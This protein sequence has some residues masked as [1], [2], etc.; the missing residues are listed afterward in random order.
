MMGH[1]YGWGFGGF[2]GF[3]MAAIMILVLG[4]IIWGVVALVR[5]TS[6][7][8]CCG[9]A[10]ASQHSDSAMEILKKRYASGEINKEEFEEKKKN[11]L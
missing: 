1:W 5:R 6:G 10:S 8:G 7:V 2:G 4:L 3:W 11:L 9:H